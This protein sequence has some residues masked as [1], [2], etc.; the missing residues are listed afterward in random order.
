MDSKSAAELV[1]E[2]RKQF[3]WSQAKLAE[4]LGFST[5]L[6]SKIEAGARVPSEAFIQA[7]ATHLPSDAEAIRNAA[8]A[9]AQ[10]DGRK[11]ASLKIVDAIKLAKAN[12]DR[13]ARIKTKAQGLQREADVAARQ[14]DE[15]RSRRTKWIRAQLG[16]LSESGSSTLKICR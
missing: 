15:N 10:P 11:S 7:M 1:V 2:A 9:E 6:I 12:G 3:G 8:S 13:A 5:I 16:A 4:T 14:L